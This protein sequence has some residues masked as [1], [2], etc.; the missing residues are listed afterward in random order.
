MHIVRRL[1]MSQEE[2]GVFTN[3]D[4]FVKYLR[5]HGETESSV[6][7][8]SLG[9]SERNIEEWS[10]MLE[11]AKMAKITY[12]MGKMYVA[13]ITAA[14]GAG[15]ETKQVVEVK[16]TIVGS[17][18]GAQL[19]DISRLT[20]RIEEFNKMV[21]ASEGVLNANSG[22]IKDTLNKIARLQEEAT[23]GF[24]EIKGKKNEIDKF[25]KDLGG[26]L[27]ALS[28]SSA[29]GGVAENRQNAKTL[30]DDIKAKVQAY[31]ESIAA[32]IKTYDSGVRDQ[33][34]KLLEFAK[35]TRTE[36]E[37]LRSLLKEEEKNL[38]KYDYAYKNY[39]NE[40]AKIKLVV[41]KNKTE[42]L[43]ATLK[44]Q[45][46]I[47]SIYQVADG[48]A[49]KLDIVL[50]KAREGL[51]GFEDLSGRLAELKKD[52]GESAN[53]VAAIKAELESLAQQLRAADAMGKAKG[54]EKQGILDTVD[55]ESAKTAAKISKQEE[56]LNKINDKV[57]DI[58]RA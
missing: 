27:A 48:E 51:S 22:T 4:A 38:Q 7:S 39:N 23:K 41:E 13:P 14:E 25:S 34:I 18:V 42:L 11:S 55:R 15:A 6:L 28:G 44:T 29:L 35:A 31:D 50:S 5:D 26:M 2:A 17:E 8:S 30:I 1:L 16:K 43:D 32:L 40:N 33:R 47:D 10:K 19:A 37:A 56:K 53:E 9:V 45:T 36:M 24:N 3:I 49:K 57:T 52:I 46:E 21:A 12:K 54:G 58:N 20:Q